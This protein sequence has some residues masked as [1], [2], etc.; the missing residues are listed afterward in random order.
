MNTFISYSEPQLILCKDNAR[1]VENEMNTF[2][3]YSE[4]QLI[5]CKD[6]A[7]R[8]KRKAKPSKTSCFQSFIFNKPVGGIKLIDMSKSCHNADFQ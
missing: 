7:R 3:S 1:R 6:N 5:L 4:P 8:D 2:I